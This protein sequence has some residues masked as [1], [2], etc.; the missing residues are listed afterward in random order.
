MQ[1][2]I[3]SIAIYLE[4]VKCNRYRSK[5]CCIVQ[6]YYN[7]FVITTPEAKVI[8][9]SK[10]LL[11][12]V[13]WQLYHNASGPGLKRARLKIQAKLIVNLSYEGINRD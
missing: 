3:L 1:Q 4:T 2:F 11:E 6:I 7:A 8:C 10:N 9:N 12:Q 13:I 5:F